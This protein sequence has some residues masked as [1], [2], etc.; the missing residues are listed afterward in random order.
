MQRHTEKHNVLLITFFIIL[1]IGAIVSK[2]INE[3]NAISYEKSEIQA[4]ADTVGHISGGTAGSTGRKTEDRYTASDPGELNADKEAGSSS[5]GAEPLTASDTDRTEESV[6]LSYYPVGNN[7]RS[8]GPGDTADINT[9]PDVEYYNSDQLRKGLLYE[10]VPY[11]EAF[12]AAQESYNIDAVFLAAV[13]AEESGYGRYTFR[14]NNIFGYG[15]RDFDSVEQCIY[16][17]ANRLRTHYLTPDGTYYEGCGVAEVGFH[18]SGYGTWVRNVS[19][20]MAEIVERIET[21]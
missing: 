9:N 17:V 11:A 6:Y 3:R 13:A 16:Y 21:Q 7:Y 8:S 20:I 12:V 4:P 10:L 1:I 15:N 5:D 2:N 14:K 18:Y 19:R